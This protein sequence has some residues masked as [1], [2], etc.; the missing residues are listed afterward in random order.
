MAGLG[1]RFSAVGYE[2]IKPLI[3]I[4][5]KPMI[6]HSVESVGLDGNWVF[7]VQRDHRIQYNLDEVLTSICANCTII[8]TGGG[9]TEGAAC[10]VLLA[11]KYIDNQ[12]PLIIINSDNIIGWD[13]EEVF[14]DFMTNESDGLILCFKATESKWSF[15]KL[16][17]NGYVDQVA[18]KD[19]ISDNATTGLYIW[20][21]GADF[22]SAA[23]GMISK[24]IRTNN[25]FYLCPVYNE[26]IEMG[27]KIAVHMVKYMH[28]VGTPEDL[29][30]F[31]N[32]VDPN[33]L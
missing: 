8:D 19:P 18:E 17:T 21:R 12:N 27:Q 7:I 14:D 20:K 31:L 24:N 13:S 29:D 32:N 25:E 11:E 2:D 10:S 6:Q 26:N 15:A 1:T 4:Y 3:P 16:G 22:V 23:K 5:G 33:N 28:G 30:Y 9:I